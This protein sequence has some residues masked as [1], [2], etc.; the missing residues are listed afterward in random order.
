MEIHKLKAVQVQSAKA[1]GKEYRLSD[2]G[3]LYLVVKTNGGKLW[4]WSYEFNGKEKLLSYGPYPAVSLSEARK[5]H[6]EAQALKRQGTDPAAAKQAKKQEELEGK[7]ESSKPTFDQ[8]TEEWFKTW[9]KGISQ[10]YAGTVKTRLE[11]DVLPAI[12]NIP[13]DQLKKADLTKIIWRIQDDRDTS[14]LCCRN[15]SVR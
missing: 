2:G 6:E 10:R 7:H 9:S 12:G 1:G 4:R 5:L 11:R 15:N 14:R 8:L 13:I 3:G